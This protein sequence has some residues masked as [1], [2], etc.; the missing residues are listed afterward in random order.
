MSSNT[1]ADSSL[2][3]LFKSFT[4]LISSDILSPICNL[5]S[6]SSPSS[7]SSSSLLFCKSSKCFI[8]FGADISDSDT[9]LSTAVSV[10]ENLIFSGVETDCVTGGCVTGAC[11][12]GACVAGACVT[13]ACVTGGLCYWRLCFWLF[14]NSILFFCSYR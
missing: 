6:S 7:S 3:G 8:S 10:L 5:S 4:S 1:G 13:G 9:L 11:V 12:T 2:R 14:L